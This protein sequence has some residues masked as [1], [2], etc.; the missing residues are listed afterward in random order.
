[1]LAAFALCG[2]A[3]AALAQKEAAKPAA[4]KAAIN[5][6][7]ADCIIYEIEASTAAPS[8]D[9]AL[10]PLAKKLKK[11]PFSSWKTFKL[12]KK[13]EKRVTR[14][15]ALRQNLVTGSKLT[16]LYRDKSTA[17]ATNKTRLRLKF[18]LDDKNDKRKLDSTINVDSGDHSL[19]GGDELKGGATYI[20]GVSCKAL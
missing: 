1:M 10:T 16:L 18:T 3:G 19:I 2:G 17:T 4:P 11:A 6:N 12:L 5:G 7:E 14:M 9:K 20:L 8:V 13:H 15:T